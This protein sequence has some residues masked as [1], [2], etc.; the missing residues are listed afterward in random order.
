MPVFK[1]PVNTSGKNEA[2]R[3]V[4]EEVDSFAE[5]FSSFRSIFESLSAE[6]KE[7]FKAAFNDLELGGNESIGDKLADFEEQGEMKA[8]V[9]ELTQDDKEAFL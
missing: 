3:G 5:S 2:T 8:F 7:A 1:A 6:E 9:D 4:E